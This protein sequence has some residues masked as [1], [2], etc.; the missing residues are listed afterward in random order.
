MQRSGAGIPAPL[1]PRKTE[2]MPLGDTE[3]QDRV[4]RVETLLEDLESL[5]DA[6]ARAMAVQTVQALLDLY[7]EGIARMMECVARLGGEQALEAVADDELVSHLLLLHG[8]HPVDVETRVLRA[9]QEVRPY[10]ESHGGNVELLRI[11][12]G[13]AYVRL[14]GSCS[15]CPSSTMTLKHAIEKAVQTAAPD[16][17]GIEAEGVT[18][19][20]LPRTLTFIDAPTTRRTAQP[21]ERSSSWAVAGGLPQLATNALLVKEIAGEA[22]L[23]LK[24]DENYYAYQHLCP[25][26]GESLECGTLE[27]AELSCPGC[28]RHYDVRRAGRCLDTPHLHLEPI[29][30][31]VGGAGIVKIALRS[32]VS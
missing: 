23:F 17:E 13:V 2:N 4:A 26:C 9:L 10:L 3:V 5:K 20:S 25:G 16:L 21:D 32:T 14:Q 8:L 18:E 15:G 19:T 6:S 7:G 30:L 24:L 11:Q 22:I 31:L 28:E 27:G 1:Q 12:E 29:P